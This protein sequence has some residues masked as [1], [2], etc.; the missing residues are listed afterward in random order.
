MN[1]VFRRTGGLA[2]L[3]ACLFSTAGCCA[4]SNTVITLVPERSV[5]WSNFL[6][7]N[8]HPLWFSQ[9]TYVKQFNALK[10]LG[11][12][13]ARIDLHWDR[14]E[15]AQ[16][17]YALSTVDTMAQTLQQMQIKSVCY[18]VGSAAFDSSAPAGVSNTDQYPP[19]NP[20]IFANRM[21]MLATR[22]P[23]VQAWEI[24]NEPNL[25]SFW[26]TAEDPTAFAQLVSLTDTA[27]TKAV[28]SK[29]VVLGGMAY[30][31]Q[32]PTKGGLMLEQLATLGV[33]KLGLVAA[34][35][36]Y[37]EY[38][39]GDVQA[40]NDFV[41]RV[42][43][44]NA[45]LR[46]IGVNTIW[47]DEWGWSSYSGPVE[48]Q[49]IIGTAGEADYLLRRLAL[50]SALDFDRT[51]LFA[52][53][54]LD[55]RASV[56]DQSY[57]LLDINGNPKPAYTALQRFLVALGPSVTPTQPPTVTSTA[58]TLYSIPWKRADGHRIWLFWGL[59]SGTATIS[60]VAGGHLLDPLTGSVS[61]I[62]ATKA[63]ELT[64]P[65]KTSLQM[66]DLG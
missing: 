66:L 15:T 6:G 28:P 37:S 32:M 54:D 5:T 20:N 33:F 18:L 63:G 55:A 31:S 29:P 45:R 61:T 8:A 26:Q 11:L 56:R 7:V 53:S 17:K 3:A 41:D 44:V 23:V 58:S 52:L 35:H 2:I 42:R 21:A 47:A 25:P 14:L 34:Y 36:P 16:G 65:V 43:I 48:A 27:L 4:A 57:G 46:G 50:I 51:F 1:T 60:G 22:Y 49:A 13:W 59:T 64:V 38:P 39:E 19:K 12:Q 24:W 62:A 40:N 10:G 30:Y 9:A